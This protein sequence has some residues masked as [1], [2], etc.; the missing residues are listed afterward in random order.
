[1]NQEAEPD[2]GNAHQTLKYMKA[3]MREIIAQIEANQKGHCYDARVTIL[4]IVT[5][6]ILGLDLRTIISVPRILV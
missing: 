2:I 1:M 3:K 6:G 5:Y 4:V